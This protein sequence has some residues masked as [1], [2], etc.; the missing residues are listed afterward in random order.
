VVARFDDELWEL[1]PED[2]GP[3]PAHLVKFVRELPEAEHALDLGCGDGRL[4]VELRAGTITAADVSEVALR[5]AARRVPEAEIAHV[6]PDEPLPF[7]DGEF[8]L[9]LC[10]ET[11]EHVRDVQLFLSEAR[12]VL[13]PGGGLALTA[14]AHDRLTALAL[15]VR[16]FESGFDPLSP[17]LRFFTRRS[18]A[19]L[20]DAMGFDVTSIRRRGGTLLA[21]A[22]R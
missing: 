10:A 16:G 21:R 7:V 2:P 12:R 6:A 19:G 1:V 4:T 3:A 14:P 11:I 17:H 9:V 5:R 15:V 8:E 20:L 22:T 18:L 13:R